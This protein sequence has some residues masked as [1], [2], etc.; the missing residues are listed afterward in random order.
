MPNSVL[1]ATAMTDSGHEIKVD[2][3]EASGHLTLDTVRRVVWAAP[4]AELRA[5]E[6]L[7]LFVRGVVLSPGDFLPQHID[8]E[9]G[10]SDVARAW[11]KLDATRRRPHGAGP[12]KITTIKEASA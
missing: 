2:V 10:R 9:Q 8:V 6:R 12:P 3:D 5:L 4:P 11:L 7:W 1:V